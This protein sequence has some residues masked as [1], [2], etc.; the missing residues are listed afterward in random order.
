RVVAAP[1]SIADFAAIVKSRER[2]KLLLV[3]TVSD[4]RGVG[5]DVWNGWK[6]EL[7]RNLY[8]ETEPVLAGGHTRLDQGRRIAVITDSLRENLVDWS[9]E[10]RDR[11]IESHYDDYWLKTEQNHQLIHAAL[12]QKAKREG[13]PVATKVLSDEF[14]SITELILYAQAHPRFISQIAGACAAAGANIVSAQI[15][16]T[17][18]GMALDTFFL[19]RE[20][21]REED[22]L[23]R[24]TRITQNIEKLL[25][26]D[27]ELDKLLASRGQSKRVVDAFTIEPVVTL[28][29]KLSVGFT[30][31]EIEALDRPGLL[32][33]V[34]NELAELN[35][36]VTSAHI[37]T[38]GERLVDSFYV[39]DL[40]GDKIIDEERLQ[41]IKKRLTEVLEVEE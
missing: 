22:E 6:G 36:S 1:K 21:D 12:V 40:L 29:N 35:L 24:A 15:S 14:T 3:L 27:I 11:Y 26:G 32:Y 17:R 7:L 20:F 4:I 34:T 38:Y 19:Q 33:D 30:V 2:L 39:K 28:D 8:N 25:H 13:Q 5:P 31:I 41:N 18:D 10:E 9:S 23:R 16:T 37:S